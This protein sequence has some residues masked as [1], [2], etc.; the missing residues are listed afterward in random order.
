MRVVGVHDASQT[1]VPNLQH[2][3]ICVDKQVGWL[4]VAVQHIG[5]VDVLQTPE[6]LVHEEPGVALRQKAPLQQL[7]QVGLH[8]LLHYV[9]R[10]DLCQRN[11][12]L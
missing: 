11:H 9:D 4:E 1:K 8:V 2:Q 7:A 10:V 3:V 6:E 5:R 12:V